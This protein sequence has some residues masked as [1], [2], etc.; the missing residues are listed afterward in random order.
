MN[1]TFINIFYFFFATQSNR[2]KV[3]LKI[4]IKHDKIIVLL[5]T[6]IFTIIYNI[7][8]YDN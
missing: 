1:I 3:F 5:Y 7:H 4:K 6:T 2:Y 8:T